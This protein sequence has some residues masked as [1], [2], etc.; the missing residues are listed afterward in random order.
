MGGSILIINPYSVDYH[1]GGAYPG[2]G[3]TALT[4]KNGFLN[5][6]FDGRQMTNNL[7]D[8]SSLVNATL[9]V[10]NSPL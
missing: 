5:L 8:H 3:F 10:L 9:S 4:E 6:T 7:E 1:M 2:F